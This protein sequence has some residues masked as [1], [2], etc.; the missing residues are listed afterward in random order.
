MKNQVKKSHANQ[1]YQLYYHGMMLPGFIFLILFNFVPMFGAIMAF[2]DYRPAKGFFGSDFVGLKHFKYLFEMPDSFELFRN[3]LIILT[4]NVGSSQIMQV[5]LNRPAEELPAAGALAEALRPVLFKA[6]KPAFLGR[7]Q[8]VPFYPISD[9]V[10][11]RIIELKLGRIRDRIAANH[12]AGFGWDDGLVE[13]VLAR[14]TEVD[15]G[16]R[17]VDHILNGTLLP[18]IAEVV[19]ARMADGKAV[20]R[21]RVTAGHKGDFKYAIK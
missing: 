11:A 14:C 19:L 8:V 12:K 9:E 6:F 21:V 16:A 7:M 1:A 18:E 17:N 2:Q 13:A 15:S 3:T 20:Q 10:L 4:S 5:C